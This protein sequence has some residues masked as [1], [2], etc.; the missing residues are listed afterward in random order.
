MG[1]IPIVNN[2]QESIRTECGPQK[3]FESLSPDSSAPTDMLGLRV[4]MV[5][6]DE[7]LIDEAHT[8]QSAEA[9]MEQARNRQ[10]RREALSCKGDNILLKHLETPTSSRVKLSIS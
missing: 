5:V 1:T 4:S 6:I 2:R 7:A 9:K 10:S 3:A 8:P